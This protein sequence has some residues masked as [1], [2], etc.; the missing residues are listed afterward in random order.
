MNRTKRAFLP[1]AAA[2]LLAALTLT[3]C[4]R[5]ENTMDLNTPLTTGAGVSVTSAEPDGSTAAPDTTL[6]Q[7]PSGE[8]TTADSVSAADQTAA[9]TPTDVSSTAANPGEST[10]AAAQTPAE[11]AK[12]LGST[13]YDILRSKA[14]T[15][16]G[17]LG[18]ATQTSPIQMS[19]GEGEVYILSEMDGLQLGIYITGKKTYI[20]LPSQKKYLKLNGTVAKLMGID[21]E[22]FSGMADEMGFDSLPPLTDAYS[23]TDGKM[24]GTACKL[25][26][27][28]NEEGKE[29]RVGMNG[30]KLVGIEY[31]NDAGSVESFM[32]FNSV[33]A[34]FPKMP[35][36]GYEEMGYMEFAKLMMAEMETEG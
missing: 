31:L 11:Y 23:L 7:E 34:G 19:V 33:T 6:P 21:P 13:E 16:D 15:I 26:M 8:V 28:K 14:M 25:F 9:V 30:K 10:T 27:I 17:S 22:E 1:A 20:Y 24:N 12:S 3:G 2:I 4:L 32:Y 5:F 29:L 18:D 35:P 36:D